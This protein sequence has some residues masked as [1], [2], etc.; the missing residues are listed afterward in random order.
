MFVSY[1][2]PWG[3]GLAKIAGGTEIHKPTLDA[4]VRALPNPRLDEVHGAY[5]EMFG[6]VRAL[7]RTGET[8]GWSRDTGNARTHML[9]SLVHWLPVWPGAVLANADFVVQ[10][11]GKTGP[12]KSYCVYQSSRLG[13]GAT[14]I[15][16]PRHALRVSARSSLRGRGRSRHKRNY[17]THEQRY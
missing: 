8:T 2:G 6:R 9:L 11:V 7:F 12:A 10:A 14:G 17:R 13:R 5:A 1:P 3:A 4:R 16:G 15:D